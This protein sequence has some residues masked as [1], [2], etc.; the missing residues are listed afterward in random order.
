MPKIKQYYK[1]FDVDHPVS[2]FTALSETYFR[3]GNELKRMAYEE[4]K[5][6]R[7]LRYSKYV[8]GSVIV[9]VAA[10]EAYFNE[11]MTLSICL[12]KDKNG[13]ELLTNCIKKL[14]N[15]SFGKE[16]M[17]DI[18]ILYSKDRLPKGSEIYKDSL[19]LIN[20]RHILVHYIP[21][22]IDSNRRPHALQRVF[23]RAGVPT[24]NTS[25]QTALGTV[26]VAEWSHDVAKALIQEFSRRT[27]AD[28]PFT[29]EAP[30][31]IE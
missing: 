31:P 30:P 7:T 14:Q 28:D 3:I 22:F 4:N 29:R 23:R 6:E 10:L 21:E 26:E 11:Q 25:W 12:M 13:K 16:K 24:I 17:N 19:A 8:Y 15:N 27:G 9:Y 5:D 1:A 20:L 18:F 2:G